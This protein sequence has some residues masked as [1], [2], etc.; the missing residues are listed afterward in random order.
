MKLKEY[1]LTEK[2]IAFYHGDGEISQGTP[3]QI[4]DL[5]KN[6]NAEYIGTGILFGTYCQQ[7][8]ELDEIRSR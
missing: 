1:R 4:Y 8:T 6:R 3:K 5:F 7:F 2:V